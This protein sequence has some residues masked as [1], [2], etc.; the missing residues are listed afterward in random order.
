MSVA[1]HRSSAY[2]KFSP[3]TKFHARPATW[4]IVFL[5]LFNL[6][7]ILLASR[8]FAQPVSFSQPTTFAVG[9][10]PRSVAVG[11]FNGDGQ[12]DLAVGNDSSVS[13]SILLGTGTGSFGPATHFDDL[14]G[15]VQLLSVSAGDFNR[16]G[17]LDL[18]VGDLN[19]V[20]ILLGTGT[21]SFGLATT[22]GVREVGA[23]SVGIGDFNG[24]GT[25]DLAVA[26]V[27]NAVSILLG[28]G[29]GSFGLA[30]T[31][32]FST[33]FTG[34]TA[35]AIADF[36][37]DGE[38]D[39]AVLGISAVSILL[40]SGS[41]S[42]GPTTAF[43]VGSVGGFHSSLASAD[44]NGDGIADI[45]VL[46]N[47]SG[48]DDRI[49]ILLGDGSGSFG[50][51]TEFVV[52]SPTSVAVG[53]FNGDGK[54]D[55]AVGHAFIVGTAI[56]L[57]DGTGSFG[58][59]VDVVNGGSIP[60]SLAIGEFNGDGKPDLAVPD[61]GS[62]TIAILL[63]TTPF[64]PP[65]SGN[66]IALGGGMIYDPDRNITWLQDANYANTSH[67]VTPGGRDV[68]LTNGQMTWAEAMTWAQNLVY[69]GSND[70]RLPTTLQPDPTCS[71]GSSFGYNCTGGELGHLYYIHLGNTP[72]DS[73]LNFGP[74]TNVT[75]NYWTSTAAGAPDNYWGF[76][77]NGGSV[78]GY[79][80]V[81]CDVACTPG[82]LNNAWAVRDGGA[83]TT[84]VTIQ[85]LADNSGLPLSGA[86]VTLSDNPSTYATDINGLVQVAATPGSKTVFA[87][88][89]GYKPV[90]QATT[91]V[92]GS[93]TVTLRLP[94]GDVLS[95][96]QVTTTPLTLQEIE[97]RGVNLSDPENFAV[98]DLSVNLTLGGTQSTLNQ[99]SVILPLNPTPGTTTAL[100]PT[101]IQFGGI[102]T[103]IQTTVIA[104]PNGRSA[105]AF[106]VL[107]AK[108]L[109]LKEFF[110][111]KAVIKNDA[112]PDFIIT[113]LSATLTV[114]T[115][116][117][118]VPLS[119]LPQLVTKALGDL[120]GGSQIEATWV[121]RGDTE[122]TYTL[123][124]SATGI[125]QP[126]GIPLTASNTG[127]VR[128]LGAPTLPPVHSI[129]GR[130]MSDGIGVPSVTLTL[131][132]GL[133]GTAATASDGTYSFSN[134][135]D[136]T[137]TITPSR[138][139]YTF[140]PTSLRLN[141]AGGD[142]PNQNFMATPVAPAAQ[143]ALIDPIP[144]LPFILAPSSV[145][146]AYLYYALATLGREVQGIAA[147]GVGH[148]LIRIPATSVNQPFSL[149]LVN[150]QGSPSSSV[151][152][153]GVLGTIGEDLFG[154]SIPKTVTVSAVNTSAGDSIIAPAAFAVY[155]APVDFVRETLAQSDSNAAQR[156]V[157]IRI[158]H[159]GLTVQQIPITVMRPPVV[160][161]HGIWSSPGKAWSR[162]GVYDDNDSLQKLEDDS[163]FEVISV[164]Y[165]NTNYEG[166]SKNAA[167]LFGDIRSHVS[168]FKGGSN[169]A[170]I[171]AAAVQVDAVAHSM[172]G[173]I[174]RAM[175]PN[176]YFRVQENYRSGLI[177]KLIT[178]N[179]P[180]LGSEFADRLY[181]RKDQYALLTPPGGNIFETCAQLF[182]DK[183]MIVGDAVRDLQT[184]SEMIATILKEK[185]FPIKTYVLVGIA[186]S[187]QEGIAENNWR[188][189]GQGNVGGDNAL[190]SPCRGLLPDY[191]FENVFG[192]GV[193]NDL[194]VSESSQR[195]HE[196]GYAGGSPPFKTSD[197]IIHAVDPS[198]FTE[199]PD[200]LD[201]IILSD[202]TYGAAGTENPKAVIDAL[203]R[204]VID[205]GSFG[206]ILP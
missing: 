188:D 153:D 195:A 141:V 106:L 77:F 27:G 132:G 144:A 62:N 26:G 31:L 18:V 154:V 157:T 180:H 21:G 43:P 158:E 92:S 74:F 16:D 147:D 161:I 86:L 125:L 99:N 73:A 47:G 118:L 44:F 192:P 100:Q 114:P 10:S 172:G 78:T 176:S 45:V 113:G 57:G 122:G 59:A 171:S 60:F 66:L 50:P 37:R 48:N 152:D 103:A 136:G 185:T 51:V 189:I 58:P 201:R 110:D 20:S 28:S 123:G 150:D 139:G 97:E 166:F 151:N 7:A 164:D 5:V 143:A 19:S 94:V 95:V 128:V 109:L 162:F 3:L 91:V 183:G 165:E 90:S 34:A 69:G 14:G 52:P 8:G 93:N 68:T 156:T 200:A 36:N 11:D 178:L 186:S 9:F 168:A 146:Q 124:V 13:V 126:F 6:W 196:L 41:G 204:P 38:P 84:T 193:S 117:T 170:G 75:T 206:D 160:L 112:S 179:T 202:G 46:G 81:F 1:W 116:L 133:G 80:R 12:T 149:T 191:N 169:P 187:S 17:N 197:A 30:T 205:S 71:L 101:T 134:L 131:V 65:S 140:T 121:V 76:I 111:V 108:L 177:H 138:S 155:R 184:D 25:L 135:I 53:D 96:G 115:G 55:L 15:L 82:F 33:N 40:G 159:G 163:R 142:V 89:D 72:D 29:T 119:G 145:N 98:Y 2:S 181:D 167:I 120:A 190:L 35:V 61:Q 137:Y 194:I 49:Y 54:I 102:E 198:L 199:G 67:Y 24:D 64:S 56:L 32:T 127:T 39:L 63:N 70:W 174:V 42:F 107:P 148:L 175:V 130:V 104:L 4:L 88:K 203:N 83:P 85:V 23:S 79:Q 129:S 182:A 173:N 105:Y 87:F 22:F